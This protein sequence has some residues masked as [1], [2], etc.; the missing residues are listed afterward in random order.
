MQ[1]DQWTRGSPGRSR[2]VGGR[3]TCRHR[4]ILV[5][6]DVFVSKVLLQVYQSL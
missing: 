1:F 5:T 3:G 6:N 2:N 4:A